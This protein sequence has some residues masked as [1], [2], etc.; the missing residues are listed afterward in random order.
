MGWFFADSHDCQNIWHNGP[1]KP[2]ACVLWFSLSLEWPAIV[3]VLWYQKRKMSYQEFQKCLSVCQLMIDFT[4]IFAQ[5]GSEPWFAVFFFI[6]QLYQNSNW[7]PYKFLLSLKNDLFGFF[8]REP[9]FVWGSQL[10]DSICG[11]PL[12]YETK[13]GRINI[14]KIRYGSST[15]L[16]KEKLF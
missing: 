4:W 9:P 11:S 14:F 13:E 10:P 6:S 16:Q 1:S 7:Y 15:F 12:N 2:L 8:Y 5:T 3:I